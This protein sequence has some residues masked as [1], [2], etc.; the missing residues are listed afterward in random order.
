MFIDIIRNN[1]E[2]NLKTRLDFLLVFKQIIAILSVFY[3][4]TWLVLQCTYS[5]SVSI[6][7]LTIVLSSFLFKKN[8]QHF[9][10][11]AVLAISFVLIIMSIV[12]FTGGV[13]SPFIIWLFV[14]IYAAGSLLG[15]LGTII[16]SCFTILFFVIITFID[17]NLE[18]WNELDAAYYNQMY[19][20]SFLSS[21]SLISFFAGRNIFKMEKEAFLQQKLRLEAE[22]S[23]KE[24]KE[25]EE[26]QNTLLSIVS[27]ELRTPAATLSMLLDPSDIAAN[28]LDAPLITKTMNHLMDVLNDMRMVKEPEV[29]L[30]TPKNAVYISECIQDA[31]HLV[32]SYVETKNLVINIHESDANKT[33]CIVRDKLV[34]QIAINIIKNCINHAK[35]TRLDI[36]INGKDL[37]DKHAFTISFTD[38]GKGISTTKQTSLFAAFVK[39]HDTS[40]GSGL[41]LY[42]SRKFARKGLDGDLKY[43]ANPDSGATFELYIEA[44]KAT[45]EFAEKKKETIAPD[46]RLENLSILLAE[47]NLVIA[48]MTQKLLK[49]NGATVHF[50]KDGEAALA[51]FKNHQIDVVLTDIF[52]PKLDGYGLTKAIRDLGF[53]G[54][55]IGCSA[56]SIG[57][58][59]NKLIAVGANKVF[60][61]PLVVSEFLSYI[62]IKVLDRRI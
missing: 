44:D 15:K 41:G 31:V 45:L 22:T 43:V 20:V 14:P 40:S 2:R 24:L 25:K 42:L 8:E 60:L 23:N 37:N 39:G 47:D 32:S 61:K 29:I 5:F 55:I 13:M 16:S 3:T 62:K 10:V 53:K 50:A 59:A 35:A 6:V 7:F 12:V 57:D 28:T 19:T 56:A 18:A 11:A 30:E 4:A 52:M 21:V 9:V 49:A 54:Q 51:L 17:L 48:M 58:E 38:N 1:F 26:E 33:R 27:H 34:K 36:T 46:V